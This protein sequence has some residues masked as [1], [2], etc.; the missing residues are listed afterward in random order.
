MGTDR[1]AEGFARA[2]TNA[3]PEP[4]VGRRALAVRPAVHVPA[5][6]SYNPD[7]APVPHPDF[8]GIGGVIK[9]R[10]DDFFVQEVPLYDPSGE[11]EHVYA[12]CRRSG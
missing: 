4:K 3:V 5:A 1:D 10:P 11:G 12:R 8:A 2:R 6:V 9:Q 7:H